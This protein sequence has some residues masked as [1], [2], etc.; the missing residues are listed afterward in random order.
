MSRYR[1]PDP[2]CRHA[3]K[4]IVTAGNALSGP[5]AATNV[6]HRP[7]CVADAIEW[8]EAVTGLDAEHRIDRAKS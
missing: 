7:E 5:H 2:L 3:R 8:A 1:V 4:G 6:C